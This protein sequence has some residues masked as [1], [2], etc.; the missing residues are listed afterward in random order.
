MGEHLPDL[1]E[2]P[3]EVGT[4]VR[5]R[6]RV[7]SQQEER[8]AGEQPD[9]DDDGGQAPD[10]RGRPGPAAGPAQVSAHGGSP[11]STPAARAASAAPVTAYRPEPTRP[12]I[13]S[14]PVT[15]TSTWAVRGP[16]TVT[17]PA[18]PAARRE[19]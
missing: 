19:E 8:N 1:G 2:E 17:S 9:Q 13:R 14:V 16:V 4:V 18:T 7:Q 12:R 3:V 15:V 11:V 5:D 10:G 6:V